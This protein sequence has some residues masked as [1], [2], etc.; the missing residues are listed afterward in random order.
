MRGCTKYETPDCLFFLFGC[1]EKVSFAFTSV[2]NTITEPDINRKKYNFSSEGIINQHFQWPKTKQCWNNIDFELA[3]KQLLLRPVKSK[4]VIKRENPRSD[5]KPVFLLD[6]GNNLKAVF[7]PNRTKAEKASALT[8]YRFSQFMNFKLVP[9]TILRTIDGMEGIVQFF[10]EGVQGMEYYSALKLKK[11]SDIYTFYF[12][13]GETDVGSKHIIFGKNCKEPALI[14]NDQIMRPSFIQFGDHPFRSYKIKNLRYPSFSYRDYGLFSLKQMKILE[15]YSWDQFRKTF[16]DMDEFYFNELKNYVVIWNTEYGRIIL[17]TL[18][19]V[20]WK[21]L[22]WI[23]DFSYPSV[24]MLENFAPVVFRKESLWQLRQLNYS[25]LVSLLPF[26][27]DDSL[28]K[29][30]ISGVLHRRDTVL[31]EAFKLKKSPEKVFERFLIEF[32]PVL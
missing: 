10:V 19:F 13:L 1:S 6:L 15:N 27:I 20:K 26:Q 2:S 22:Y 30:F 17:Q 14:D 29:W 8:A 3:E 25:R 24:F 23:R 31:K 9:P 16:N 4:T 5:K 11:K 7:K 21:N 18:Y 12:V 32:F 28:Q